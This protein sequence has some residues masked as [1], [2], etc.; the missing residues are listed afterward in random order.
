MSEESWFDLWQ[1]HKI[2]LFF[3]VARLVMGPTQPFV[4]V[5]LVSSHGSKVAAV[6]SQPV[7]LLQVWE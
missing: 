3:R 1:G 7:T 4:Q 6:S 5:V 2:Y